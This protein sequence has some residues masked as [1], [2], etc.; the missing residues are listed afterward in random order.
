MR[1]IDSYVEGVERMIDR[2]YQNSLKEISSLSSTVRS[3]FAIA[4]E[5]LRYPAL[6]SA[7]ASC[8]AYLS[9]FI[10]FDLLHLLPGIVSQ[11]LALSEIT[12]SMKVSFMVFGG[13][14]C[15]LLLGTVWN[16]IHYHA[17]YYTHCENI[18]DIEYIELQRQT[19]AE[20]CW[21]RGVSGLGTL[22][23]PKEIIGVLAQILTPAQYS[24]FVPMINITHSLNQGGVLG[25][26]A[27]SLEDVNYLKTYRTNVETLLGK[28]NYV[29]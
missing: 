22:R 5:L 26:M 18:G 9:S 29:F 20:D 6:L 1:K 19:C 14:V 13:Y 3:Q 17:C 12:D 16:Y 2:S 15:L 21:K 4:T 25:V 27:A 28:K 11:I 8:I 7:G 10:G 24:V 23:V